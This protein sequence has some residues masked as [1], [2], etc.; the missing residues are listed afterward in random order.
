MNNL[1]EL[2]LLTTTSTTSDG[3]MDFRYGDAQTVL[4]NRMKFFKR[5]G[6]QSS[7]VVVMKVTHEDTIVSVDR[8]DGGK[9]VHSLENAMVA[10]ALITQDSQVVLMLLTADC[11]P[12]VL[13]D[14]GHR[15]V[16]LLHCGW[17]P[18]V[19]LLAQKVVQYMQEHYETEP[20]NLFAYIAPGIHKESYVLPEVEQKNEARW[21]P[22]ITKT[23]A[24]Y[25]VD[26][27]ACNTHLLTEVGV[28]PAH[29]EMSE[30]DT[31]KSAA[32]FSHYRSV[33]TG[34]AE[35]RM[36]TLVRLPNL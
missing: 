32:Y 1:E 13:Y 34:E 4:E 24:G 33:K 9:G 11:L 19:R 35:G 3:N 12:I 6:V 15:V 14:A 2:E 16:A 25:E 21:R 23:D 36:A 20:D 7:D 31:G 8:T 18:T 29:I 5:Y 28:L 22:F 26:L 17:K 10:E 30:H 27:V